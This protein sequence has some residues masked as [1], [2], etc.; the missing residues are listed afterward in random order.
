LE[1]GVGVGELALLLDD[2]PLQE[3][4][5]KQIKMTPAITDPFKFGPILPP[6]NCRL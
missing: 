5:E 4:S 3:Q 2:G 1:A 6:E